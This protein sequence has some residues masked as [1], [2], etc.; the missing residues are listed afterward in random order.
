MENKNLLEK[1]TLIIAHGSKVAET[2]KIMNQYMEA[3]RQQFPSE[4]FEKCYL[5]LMAPLLDDVIT[6]LYEDGVKEIIAFP[7]FLFNGNHIKE[8][9]PQA[10]EALREKHKDL[11]ITFLSNIG[12]DEKLVTLIG[13]RVGLLCV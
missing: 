7:L 8:D 2:D 12:F 1:A 6:A 3:L 9:I 13:E 4:R 10:L 11:K 5:Q